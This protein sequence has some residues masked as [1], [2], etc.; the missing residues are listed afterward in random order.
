[1]KGPGRVAQLVGRLT[2]E[3]RYPARPHTFVSPLLI[4]EGQL[5][6]TGHFTQMLEIWYVALPRGPY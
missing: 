4:L 5:S 2:K 1:M 6:V 3:V